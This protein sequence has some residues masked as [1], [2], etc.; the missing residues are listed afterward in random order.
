MSIWALYY[1]RPLALFFVSFCFCFMS[2]CW[3]LDD[4]F[5]GVFSMFCLISQAVLTRFEVYPLGLVVRLVVRFFFWFSSLC[6][7]DR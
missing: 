2:I 3:L 7:C 6:E 5:F 4:W 1:E